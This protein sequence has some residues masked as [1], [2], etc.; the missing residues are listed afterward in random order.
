MNPTII[1][2]DNVD[3]QP[4]FIMNVGASVE[5]WY[6]P[7]IRQI[8]LKNMGINPCEWIYS[9]EATTQ[10]SAPQLFF[11]PLVGKTP[12]LLLPNQNQESGNIV[13]GYFSTDGEYNDRY[14]A[15]ETNGSITL[16]DVQVRYT[17]DDL[18]RLFHFNCNNTCFESVNTVQISP[19]SETNY[20]VS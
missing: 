19:I 6:L 13:Y 18:T 2:Y 10:F 7:A 5:L 17:E 15:T 3:Q 4:Q 20:V 12:P 11:T 9:G 16:K 1:T 14:S 8:V